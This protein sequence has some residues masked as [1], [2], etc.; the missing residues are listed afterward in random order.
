MLTGIAL[1]L[2]LTGLAGLD[3]TLSVD[4]ARLALAARGILEHGGPVLPSGWLYTRGPLSAYAVA[5]AFA[6]LGESDFAARLPSVLA[7]AA[8]VPVM[9]WLGSVLAGRLG[10]LF[11]AAFVAGY[12]PL[13]VWSRSAWFYA[14]YVL[15]FA[16][17]LLFIVRAQR[18]GRRGDQILAGGLTGATFFAH[19]LGVLLLIPLCFQVAGALYWAD[20]RGRRV[21]LAALGLALAALTLLVVLV[22]G[23]RAATLVGPYGEVSEYVRPHLDGRPFRFYG[24][25]LADR[26]WLILAAALIGL[27]LAVARR[28]WMALLLWLALVPSFLHAVTIIPDSPQERYGLTLVVALVALAAFGVD[29]AASWLAGRVPRFGGR[30]SLLGGLAFATMVLVHQDV[31]QAVERAAFSPREGAWLAEARALGIGTTDLV[32]SDLPTVTGWYV[33]DVDFWVSSREFEKYTLH[34]DAYRDVHTGAVLIRGAG[35]FQRLVARPHAGRT[36]WVFASDRSYQWGE[37]VDDNLKTLLE[38][39]ASRRINPGAGGHILR[40]DL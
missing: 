8:L 29:Q 24:R 39:S 30:S 28:Q 4:E 18:E 27:P 38:R 15:L 13:V 20:R 35:E 32:M 31:G 17:A 37:L 6:C 10:G 22:T 34:S 19:E 26:Y 9:Y 14:L 23:L 25:M 12:P 7:G 2:R 3:G 11:A 36:L 1:W 5:F 16:A 33:G 21:A 40:I